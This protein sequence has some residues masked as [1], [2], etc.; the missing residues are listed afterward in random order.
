MTT[1]GR[2]SCAGCTRGRALLA[3]R[4]LAWPMVPQVVNASLRGHTAHAVAF[5]VRWGRA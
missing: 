1:H 2:C 3:W 4:D 5:R